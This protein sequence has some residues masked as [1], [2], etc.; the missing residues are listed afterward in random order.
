MD[1][2]DYKAISEIIRERIGLIKSNIIKKYQPILIAEITLLSEGLA[3]YF[4]KE[5]K[6]IRVYAPFKKSVLLFKFNRKQ[7]LKDCG[8]TEAMGNGNIKRTK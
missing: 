2:K 6:G 8:I 4:E 3:N 1:K 7:F 5:D